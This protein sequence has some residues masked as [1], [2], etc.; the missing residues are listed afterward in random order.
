MLWRSDGAI[1]LTVSGGTPP[2]IFGWST[3]DVTEDIINQP[4]NFYFFN[5]DDANGCVTGG[6]EFINDPA[7]IVI[8]NFVPNSGGAGVLVTINGS[9][10]TG[11][12]DVRQLHI[13]LSAIFKLM[14]SFH[15]GLIPAL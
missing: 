6:I 10:F 1:D 4:A 7:Q 2:Y 5:I 15:Q 3:G 13:L 11:A 14:L 9:G 8:S 12:T